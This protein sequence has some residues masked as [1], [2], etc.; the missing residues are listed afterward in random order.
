M[1]QSIAL[2]LILLFY[3]LPDLRSQAVFQHITSREIY[4]FLDEL[5]NEK[6]IDINSVV[7]PYSRVYIAGKLKEA[8]GKK[9][10]LNPRQ[11]KDLDFYLRDYAMDIDPKYKFDEKTNLLKKYDPL[12]TSHNPLGIHF[13]DKFFKASLRPVW[14]IDYNINDDGTNYHRWGGAEAYAEIG[15][16]WAFYASLRDNT[17]SERLAESWY[18][19]QNAG[20]PYKVLDSTKIG[21]D[22][23]E[24]RGGIVY[25][26]KWGAF[27]LVKDHFTWGDNYHGSNIFSG[28][29]PSFP[30]IYLHIEPV[31]WFSFNYIHAWLVSEVV[32]SLRTYS[33]GAG[34]REVFHNKY[35]AANLF[36]FEPFYNLKVSFGNSIVYSDLGVHPAYLVPFLFYKS[37]DHTLNSTANNT[38]QNAQMYFNI[39]SR[40][41][42]HLHLYTS[43]FIDELYLSNMFDKEKQSNWL[44]I[45]GGFRVSNLGIPNLSLT[46]E[47]TRTNPITYKH[48][49]PTTSFETNHFNLGHYLRDNSQE[50]YISAG[51]K[52]IR[53]LKVELSYTLAQIGEDYPRTGAMGEKVKGLP[54]IEEVKGEAGILSAVVRYEFINNGFVF[55]GFTNSDYSGDFNNKIPEFLRDQKQT[56]N[57]GFNIGF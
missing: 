27:G 17:E 47:Y 41:I 5:A 14:G 33:Y 49:I 45:K 16:N 50:M 37:V 8:E 23:S 43:V 36:T 26:W 57:T 40:Q 4:E 21:G 28:R 7:K 52:P 39:S 13:K 31:S 48:F 53:G 42:K 38:G 56:I 3:F 10:Q 12:G 9:A 29:T 25:S 46:A 1:K 18:L 54:F 6:I 51:Y 24:T 34:K 30:H 35:L 44:S 20:A 11:Q 19:T 15:K 55:L 32:D 2:S 22:Y